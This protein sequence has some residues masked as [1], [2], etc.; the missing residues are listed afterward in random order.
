M[1]RHGGESSSLLGEKTDDD[2]D[3]NVEH[4]VVD[5]IVTPP[6]VVDSDISLVC[7]QSYHLSV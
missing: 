7:N 1:A 6:A 3:S 5:A 4:F 2:F